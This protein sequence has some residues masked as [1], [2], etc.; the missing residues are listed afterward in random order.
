MR[1]QFDGTRVRDI[2]A[3][4]LTEF[5]RVAGSVT[6]VDTGHIRFRREYQEFV[7]C[8]LKNFLTKRSSFKLTVGSNSV[9][10]LLV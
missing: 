6:T 9:R 4:G 2:K 8:H 7:G 10:T 1:L 5:G 3:S